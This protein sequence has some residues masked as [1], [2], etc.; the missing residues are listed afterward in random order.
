MTD[1]EPTLWEK[2]RGIWVV[3][4]F[5]PKLA[6]SIVV[7]NLLTAVFEG[8]GL[9]FLLPIIEAAQSSGGITSQTSGVSGYF[10]QVYTVLGV[11]FSLETL[12]VGLAVVM[13]VRFTMTFFVSWLQVLLRTQYLFHLRETCYDALLAADVS[14]I[15]DQD[16]DDIMNTIVTEI[17]Q[18]SGIISRLLNV[19]QTVFLAV[20]YMAVALLIAPRLTVATVG[21][22][23]I[24]IFL[25]RYV[26]R[27]GYEIG[28][29]VVEA[30][31]R[32]QSLVNAGTQG[33]REIKVFNMAD[34]LRQQYLEE[35]SKL[36]RTRVTLSRNQAALKNYTQ[37]LNALA[38]FALIYVAIAQLSLSFASLGVFLFAMFRLSPMISTLNNSLYSLDGALPHLTRSRKLIDELTVH[39]EPSGSEP[40]PDPVSEIRVQDVSFQ[41]DGEDTISDISMHVE[42][43]ETVA[44][45]G[46][47]GAG[48][49]T[50]ISLIARLYAPDTGQIT[51]NSVPLERIDSDA[52]HERIAIVPQHPFIFNDTLRYNIAVG[53]PDATDEEIRRV[54]EISQVS[55]FLD[56][57]PK[58]LDSPLGDDAVRLSG[59]QRQRVAIA[60][61]LLTDADVLLLDE[62]TSEL[63]S[64]T[65]EAILSGIESMDQ[66][67]LTVVI[68]HWVSTVQDAD[69]VYT[70]VD[71]ELVEA[72][73][74]SE[75]L[76]NDSHYTALYG[77]QVNSTPQQ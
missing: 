72:G 9:G 13:T 22:L 26:V 20:A 7:L 44:L 58:G 32:I 17:P 46:P 3:L 37:L 49:S 34:S 52:W 65:E 64:P 73:T 11:P 1:E 35:H 69:R 45:V 75:L 19:I 14:F 62:A 36:V 31:E 67:F 28:D 10:L 68:G 76:A 38:L 40:A 59:G 43:G 39:T 27:S 63:D 71:G 6:L 50:I 25:T 61:A 2:C 54:C 60:R 8:I 15:E 29:R 53:N 12:I 56:E 70:I 30:N 16:R 42:R 33:I 24:V 5:R 23:G 77:S 48:K 57:L 47:S 74:H 4:Q 18:S 66:E 51:A 41:Y 55:T 21:L